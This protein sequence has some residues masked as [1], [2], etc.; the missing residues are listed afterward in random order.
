[1]TTAKPTRKQPKSPLDHDPAAVTWARNAKG[2]TQAALAEAVGIS[3][4][5]MSEVEAGSRNAPPWLLIKLAEALNC[6]VSVLERKRDE[7]VA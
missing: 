2:W 4:A 7:A 6:P 3:P 5:H 1:M